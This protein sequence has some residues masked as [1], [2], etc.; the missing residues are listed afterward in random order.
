MHVSAR[1]NGEAL[2]IQQPAKDGQE[3]G[4]ESAWND[5]DKGG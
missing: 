5:F 2:R 4:E 3:V 1:G